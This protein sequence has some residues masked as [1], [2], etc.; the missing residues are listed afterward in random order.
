MIHQQLIL[1]AA[2]NPVTTIA[3]EFG[4][5]W[6]FLIAQA[7][8]FC[9][10]AFLIYWFGFRPLLATVDERQKKIAEGLQYAEEMKEKLAE[11]EKKHQEILKEASSQAQKIV[12]EARA[13]SK[14]L[15]ERQTQEA[16]A[17]SEE[18]I[19]K[20]QEA[21]ELDRKKMLAEARE[22]IA[23]L[24]VST[25]ARVLKSELS[26]DERTRYSEAATRELSLKG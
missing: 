15:V 24:V 22:E 14:E 3:R 25:A 2:D 18:M 21:I 17:R 20:A 9:V 11:A 23:R 16:A 1:A 13:T 19:R 8:S 7:L 5:D 12:D 6:P 26:D 10:V 4:V